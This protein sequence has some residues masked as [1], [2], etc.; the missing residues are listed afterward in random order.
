[1]AIE[2][3]CRNEQSSNKDCGAWREI[4]RRMYRIIQQGNLKTYY[5][6]KNLRAT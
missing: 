1:M 6:L 5:Y 4:E 2:F 3:D